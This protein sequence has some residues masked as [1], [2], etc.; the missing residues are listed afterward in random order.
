LKKGGEVGG[1]ILN[2][3]FFKRIQNIEKGIFLRLF[4][5]GGGDVQK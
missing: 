4:S 2:V 1:D 3:F 5:G